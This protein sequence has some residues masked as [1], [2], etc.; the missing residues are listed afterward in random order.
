MTF[1][2]PTILPLNRAFTESLQFTPGG[3]TECT[4]HQPL[5][6][7]HSLCFSACP[8]SWTPPI[9]PNGL[10]RVTRYP[11]EHWLPWNC[12]D[13]MGRDKLIFQERR[14]LSV[15]LP[16]WQCMSHILFLTTASQEE[17]QVLYCALL[18]I[19]FQ[20]LGHFNRGKFW[21]RTGLFGGCQ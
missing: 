5:P 16:V 14:A 8:I 4:P 7:L 15:P 12:E 13:R 20:M 10:W 2:E 17:M 11:E 1:R 21:H 6:P 19:N 9:N 3:N 18:W